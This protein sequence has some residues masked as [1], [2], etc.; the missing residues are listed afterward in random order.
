[1]KRR[2]SFYFGVVS[3][4][5]LISMSV[6]AQTTAFSYQGSLNTSGTPTNGNHDFEFAM[7][8]VG[9]VQI[10]STLTRLNVPVSNA[11][12][13]VELDFGNQFQ[14]ADRFLEIRVRPAGGGAF[15]TLTPRQLLTS[16]PHA[17]RSLDTAQ[18]GGV[19]ASQFVQ[20]GTPV[21]NAGTG[22]SI[23]GQ[24]VLNA[25]QFNT[26]VGINAG[27]ATAGGSNS[28]FGAGAGAATTTGLQ[29]SYFGSQAGNAGTTG[30][31]NTFVGARAGRL[32]TANS[33]SFFGSG[34]GANNTTG[35][36]NAF[37]GLDSGSANTTQ[38]NNSYF[39]F[40]A[41][42]NA[43]GTRNAFFG[44]LSGSA[45]SGNS[46][47]F[48]G[49]NTGFRNTGGANNAFFGDQAGRDNT[50]ASENSFFGSTAGV[51]NT[52]GGPNSF[53]GYLAGS[54]NTIGSRNS[55]FGARAGD[56]NG[57]GN[58]NSFF[59]HLA[60]RF[61]ST[62][63][64]NSFFGA[65]VGALHTTGSRNSF[66]GKSAGAANLG[67]NDNAFFGLSAGENNTEGDANSFFGRSAGAG[68]TIGNFLTM[69]GFEAK[70]ANGLGNATAIGFRAFVAQ[71][72]SLVLGGIAGVNGAANNT[73]VGIGTSTPSERLH[74]VG[75]ALFSGN[76]SVGGAFGA[77][78][79]FNLNGIRILATPGTSNLFVGPDSGL[80]NTTGSANA[81]FASGS[82][83]DN[84]AGS[85]NSF[86]GVNTGRAN[87]LGN[88]NTYFGRLAGRFNTTGSDNTTIGHSAGSA[89]LTGSEITAVGANADVASGALTNATAIGSRAFV[90]SGNSLVLGSINGVNGAT[91]NTRVGIGTTAPI[92]R[93]TIGDPETPALN[94]AVGIFNA[95]GTFLTVR[96]TTNDIEGF[97]GA[98]ANG[99]LFGS[100]TNSI[101]RIRTGNTNRLSFDTG[102]NAVFSNNLVI[103]GFTVPT[104][105]DTGGATQVCRNVSN[106]LSTCSSSQRYKSNVADFS[107]GLDLIRR[108]RPVSFNWRDGGM[109]DLGLVAEE[110]ARVEPLL[111]TTTAKGDV[112]GVK[113]D[114]VGVVLVN[115]IKEQQTQI[116]S[117]AET[118]MRQQQQI[119]ALIR[120]VCLSNPTAVVCKDK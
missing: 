37:F 35:G 115:A 90:S 97:V 48:F 79:Q 110:V 88:R 104:A 77:T 45:T 43:T 46:N 86:Y 56:N 103:D 66:F 44:T 17:I 2:L 93:L 59:G 117:Q 100:L 98:D 28:F 10:G 61:N 65:S 22:F 33:N 113:Y 36:S 58:D 21:I 51:L 4:A 109:L 49:S 5:L 3:L 62:G 24:S 111:T 106:R 91:A 102:G 53:F 15:T 57:T 9:G 42:I 83:Q 50:T 75:N 70:G 14:G 112:E 68:N 8:T 16:T 1:M 38:D 19:A 72:D 84:T 78:T 12:F 41:G 101:V 47:A 27:S 13:A 118:I 114:R 87:T 92:N 89:N 55:F 73:K 119:D 6:N 11:V 82:G 80:A 120:L 94:G 20:T 95:G 29:N 63:N 7:F 74:V 60:G 31:N 105:L 76:L 67:G 26:S 32:N 71:D 64:D 81:F 116:E 69:I 23:G 18:L 54:S 34:A 25:T 40:F 52:T 30:S 99:V 85:D 39:G 108:L 107:A 96:D